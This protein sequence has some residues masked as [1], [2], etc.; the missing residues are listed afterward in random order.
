MPDIWMT[1][2]KHKPVD[3]VRSAPV[4]IHE[5]QRLDRY[6]LRALMA[7]RAGIPAV[8]D[9][10][11]AEE[12]R[13]INARSAVCDHKHKPFHE[14]MG[15]AL[16]HIDPTY[17]WYRETPLNMVRSALEQPGIAQAFGNVF[18][19]SLLMGFMAESDTSVGWA[20]D[21][22]ISTFKANDRLRLQTPESLEKVPRGKSAKEFSAEYWK[23]SYAAVRFGKYAYIDEQDMVDGDATNALTLVPIELGKAARRL[24]ADLVYSELLFNPEMADGVAL[25]HAD[26]GNYAT[27]AALSETTLAAGMAAMQTQTENGVNLNIKPK[28]LVVPP[29]LGQTARKLVRLMKTDDPDVDLTVRVESRL[30]NGVRDPRFPAMT[31]QGSSTTWYLA[32]S[33]AQAPS[34]LFGSRQDRPQVNSYAHT[35]GGQWGMTH[36]VN[37]DCGALAVAWEGLYR[38]DA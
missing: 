18:A 23:S 4:H 12:Q 22:P 24:R 26:H 14:V 36:Q 16:Q 29:A 8:E 13:L 38:A 10:M 34:I 15:R 37:Y 33:A 25:F 21:D 17:D 27:G 19:T 3:S 9:W 30:Q 5:S 6:G 35:S 20:S 7:V 31:H 11:P 32:A 2:N 1:R 28:Y